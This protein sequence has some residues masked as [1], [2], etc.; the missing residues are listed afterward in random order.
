MLPWRPTW[1]W[2]HGSHWE[3]LATGDQGEIENRVELR[4][5]SHILVD[6]I[7]VH[8]RGPAVALPSCRAE[9]AALSGQGAQG[10]CWEEVGSPVW[11]W[12]PSQWA[13]VTVEPDLA[14][15]LDR[16]VNL[17][18]LHFCTLRKTG[19]RTWEPMNPSLQ[20]CPG[21][22]PS[23]KPLPP[24]HIACGPIW[25]GSVNNDSSLGSRKPQSPA[26]NPAH[27]LFFFF[28]H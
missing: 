25:P 18:P 1:V 4:A 19:Q 7:L 13:I 5:S 27:L 6:C 26:N 17:Q 21:K 20:P 22:E 16:E 2:S 8:S 23:Q 15:C 9:Q 11:S 12:S 24:I 3:N 28:F 10:W 14:L